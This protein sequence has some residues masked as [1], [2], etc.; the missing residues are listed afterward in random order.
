MQ[1]LKKL[2]A[3]LGFGFIALSAATAIA[4]EP[5]VTLAEP[6]HTDSGKKVEVLEFFWYGCPHCYALD[7][8][9]SD[10]VKKQGDAITFKRIPVAFRET[11]V[12]MQK[13]YYSLEAMGKLEELHAKI[14]STIHVA[15][16]RIESDE[17]V[18]NFVV[19]NGIDK[20]KFIDTYGSFSTQT[21]VKRASQLQASYKIDGVPHVIV[22]GRYGTSPAIVGASIGNQSE[23]VLFAEMSKVLDELVAKS[24][25]KAGAK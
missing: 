22:N 20:Q 19:K 15:K 4:A 11:F 17:A 14:F 25:K 18:L 23:S 1:L 6:Q 10:W 9:L 5:Y 12:P 21:K 16:Q 13:L 7:P 3:T 8:S 24:V 2:F